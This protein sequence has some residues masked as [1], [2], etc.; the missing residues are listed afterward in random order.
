MSA[1]RA[2]QVLVVSF[3]RQHQRES[4]AALEPFPSSDVAGLLQSQPTVTAARVLEHMVP[5]RL[6]GVLASLDD[7]S[8]SAIVPEIAAPRL[9]AALPWL[10]DDERG[11]LLGAL[12]A[13]HARE[14]REQLSFPPDT[15]GALMDTR[16]VMVR[17]S[18]SVAEAIVS[19]RE[20]RTPL[21]QV[22]IVDDERHLLGAVPLQKLAAADPASPIKPLVEATEGALDAFSPREEVAA[23]LGRNALP[24]IAVI[25]GAGRLLGVLRH[26]TLVGVIEQDVA[27]DMQLMVGA[28]KDEHALS[29]V[30]FAVKKRLPWLNINLLTAFLAAS[31][32]GLFESTISQVTSLAILLPVVAGQSGNSGSQALAVTMR[33]LAV[34]E[35]L[36]ADWWRV[37]GKEIL[38]GVINGVAIAIV[39]GAGV[40]VWSRSWALAVVIAA[41]MVL[42]MAAAG[43]AGASIPI[44]LKRLGMDPAVSSSIILTTV[45]DVTGFFGFLGLAS[46]MM[47]YLL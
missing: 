34:R 29:P 13:H 26:R 3:L 37:A 28:S 16:V 1:D 47:V 18:D 36:T 11:R 43:L 46:L 31:V 2:R 40:L 30:G 44:L 6:A 32:V 7:S 10:D 22:Y 5:Q 14:V 42:A 24:S 8:V 9:A 33:G 39:T 20:I 27:A 38:V 15:A 12:P 17:P 21:Y 23:F 41:S 45:T 4:A 35:I 25:D 19:L